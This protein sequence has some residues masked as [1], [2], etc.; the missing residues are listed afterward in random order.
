MADRPFTKAQSKGA[1]GKEKSHSMSLA[2]VAARRK[3]V[4]NGP[5]A[6]QKQSSKLKVITRKYMAASAGLHTNIC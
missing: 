6:L 3:G 4:N 2:T 1:Q 5:D